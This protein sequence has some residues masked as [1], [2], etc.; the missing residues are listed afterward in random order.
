MLKYAVNIFELQWVLHMMWPGDCTVTTRL[1]V[2]MGL[3][4]GYKSIDQSYVYQIEAKT[5]LLFLSIR[6]MQG[7]KSQQNIYWNDEIVRQR[8]ISPRKCNHESHD[9]RWLIIIHFCHRH[10]LVWTCINSVFSHCSNSSIFPY[11]R[12]LSD[13]LSCKFCQLFWDDCLIL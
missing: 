11:M 2:M 13:K 5:L 7:L 8:I 6:L 3:V 4:F 10:S 12:P 9:A 1:L